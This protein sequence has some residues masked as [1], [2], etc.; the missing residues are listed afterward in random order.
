MA[1]KDLCGEPKS[2]SLKSECSL[3]EVMAGVILCFHI[4][5]GVSHGTVA[6][7]PFSMKSIIESENLSM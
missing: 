3:L 4:F 5:C 7:I 2:L 6:V 1:G